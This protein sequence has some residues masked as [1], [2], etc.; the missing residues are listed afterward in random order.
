MEFQFIKV[1]IFA[2]QNDEIL[3][4][5]TLTHGVEAGQAC[6]T[7][8]SSIR[9]TALARMGSMGFTCVTH[10]AGE[11][12]KF[13]TQSIFLIVSATSCSIHSNRALRAL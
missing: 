8:R 12:S 4:F 2:V 13:E 1:T 5:R 3:T 11:R 6:V 9:A 7:P 10:E